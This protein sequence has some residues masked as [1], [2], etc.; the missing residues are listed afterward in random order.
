MPDSLLSTAEQ[1]SGFW[2]REGLVPI[3]ASTG[4]ETPHRECRRPVQLVSGEGHGSTDTRVDE[5][6][7]SG[8]A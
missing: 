1:T 3:L 2:S 6:G 7:S 4:T 8:L 5:A